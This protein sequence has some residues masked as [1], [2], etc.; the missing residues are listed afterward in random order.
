MQ[1]VILPFGLSHPKLMVPN[2]LRLLFGG[3][4]WPQIRLRALFTAHL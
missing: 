4:R 1:A 3:N 2:A